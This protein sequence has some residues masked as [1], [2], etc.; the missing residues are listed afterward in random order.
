MKHFGSYFEY[1]KERN[2]DLMRAF[3]YVMSHRC[4]MTMEEV[5]AKTVEMPS[6]R[7]WVSEQ[8]AAG[9]VLEMMKGDKLDTMRPN[10]RAMFNEIYRRFLE[11]KK[12]RPMDS[13]Y[14]ITFDVVNSHAPR[15]Y[16]TPSFAHV[17]ISK[18]KRKWYKAREQFWAEVRERS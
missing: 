11:L 1:E 18:I 5:F 2:R 12:T 6:V 13:V 9:V 17:I 7:F 3:K 4:G 10:K 15:F 16:L 14:D 8:R